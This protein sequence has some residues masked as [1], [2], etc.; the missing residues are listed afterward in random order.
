MREEDGTKN[1]GCWSGVKKASKLEI[2]RLVPMELC[3]GRG[4]SPPEDRGSMIGV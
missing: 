2:A 1:E 3:G 4:E